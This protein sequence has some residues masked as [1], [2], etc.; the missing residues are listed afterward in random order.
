MAKFNLSSSLKAKLATRF[1]ILTL[2]FLV[3]VGITF[4]TLSRIIA[5][6]K[7]INTVY[8]PSVQSVNDY[9]LLI[10]NSKA[11]ISNWVFVQSDNN[12][13]DKQRLVK[14]TDVENVKAKQSL[15]KLA[16]SW[17]EKDKLL[18]DSIFKQVDLL[19]ADYG[20]VRQSLNT[21]ES[22]SDPMVT[23][24][25]NS[26]MTMMQEQG[27]ITLSFNK[28]ISGLDRLAKSQM[29]GA[30]KANEEMTKVLYKFKV[31]I[32]LIAIVTLVLG[33]VIT[34]STVRS[35]TVP[36]IHV[37]NVLAKMGKGILENEK[38]K[39]QNNEIGEMSAALNYL[40]QGLKETAAYA[41]KIGNGDFNASF[42][43]LS[44]EDILGNSLL[45]MGK[46][47]KT[48]SEEEKKRNWVT[49]GLAK[50]ADILRSN[51]DVAELSDSIIVNV[52]KYLGANQGGV[53]LLNEDDGERKLV[54]TACYAYERKKYIEKV[55]REG[56][57]LVGQCLLE[58]DTIYLT[59]VPNE[60]VKITSG[61]GSA[62]PN[63][64]VVQPLVI[65]DD[66]VGVIEIASFK[67]LDKFEMEFLSKLSENI[68]SVISSV[69]VNERTVKLLEEA[70]MS[71]EALKSQEEELRQNLEELTATQEEVYRKENEYIQR[72][73]ELE[74]QLNT[75]TTT[76]N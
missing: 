58:K 48:L 51:N 42:T 33:I 62:N 5:I 14:V 22:Y 36:I 69:K 39:E 4:Y 60:Y 24:G 20:S 16:A 65:N 31:F 50:F 73:Q 27:S 64:I 21:F 9:K 34:I 19:F 67:V 41:D 15:T 54:L 45:E 35:I 57:G 72:I 1:G 53:F 13:A 17:I 63:C 32:S 68:A 61:L 8:T 75:T 28:V 76:L 71:H 6:N 59:E 55:I 47:L 49:S 18:L 2:L 12:N 11:L 23:M 29:E 30:K 38:L 10:V 70:K 43:P 52:V 37:K 46:K 40:S 44:Q 26:P 56:E 66:L 25:I 74:Q 3:G 7:E